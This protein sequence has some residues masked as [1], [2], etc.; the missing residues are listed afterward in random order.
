MLTQHM[1]DRYQ[2]TMSYCYSSS[3][4]EDL[5]FVDK[6]APTQAMIRR[7]ARS[8]RDS[9]AYNDAPMPLRGQNLTLIGAMALR[10]L[11]G[12]ITNS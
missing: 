11:V 2:K 9:R 7:Y 5:V 8:R 6:Q 12:E 1:V 3:Q 10:G 4:L